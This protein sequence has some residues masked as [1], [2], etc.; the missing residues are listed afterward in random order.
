MAIVLITEEKTYT[1]DVFGAE[2]YLS[3][4]S[5]TEMT[6]LRKKH[7]KTMRGVEVADTD[8]MYYERVDRTIKGWKKGDVQG[9]VDGVVVDLECT[10]ENKRILAERNAKY[11]IEALRQADELDGEAKEAAA[12]N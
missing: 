1:A 3:P 5:N 2:M 6:N 4:M 11:A 7:T 12:K 10:K 8:A 9:V